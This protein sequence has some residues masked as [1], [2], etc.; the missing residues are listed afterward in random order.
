[1]IESPLT[2]YVSA[3]NLSHHVGAV[4][5][6]T[7]NVAMLFLTRTNVGAIMDHLPAPNQPKYAIYLL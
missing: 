6:G 7:C 1:M 5:N 3:M 4:S 2:Y